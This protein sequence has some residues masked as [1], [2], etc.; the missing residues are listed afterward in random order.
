MTEFCYHHGA[1]V[2]RATSELPRLAGPAAR[3][4]ASPR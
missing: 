3:P 2:R 4:S 1:G